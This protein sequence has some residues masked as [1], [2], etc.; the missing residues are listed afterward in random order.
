M[1]TTRMTT[2]ETPRDQIHLP[3][4]HVRDERVG[5]SPA[6]PVTE[7]VQT[8]RRLWATIGGDDKVEPTGGRFEFPGFAGACVRR[9]LPEALSRR[10][11]TGLSHARV[12]Q[13]GIVPIVRSL[14]RTAMNPD[15][16]IPLSALLP[17]PVAGRWLRISIWPGHRHGFDSLGFRIP[18]PATRGSAPWRGGE[19][20]CDSRWRLVAGGDAGGRRVSIPCRV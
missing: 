11:G 4:P 7:F 20:G 14:G 6:R 8:D 17:P 12:C 10:A 1:W 16:R 2:G 9:V 3:P 13:A 18:C 5:P 19:S 15:L